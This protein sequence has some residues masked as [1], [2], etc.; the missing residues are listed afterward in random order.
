VYF[1]FGPDFIA[2]STRLIINLMASTFRGPDQIAPEGPF[3]GARC[4]I[5]LADKLLGALTQM[6]G[7]GVAGMAQY[8]AGVEGKP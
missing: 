7:A 4:L 8:A 2:S 5:A 3:E 6:R 1:R